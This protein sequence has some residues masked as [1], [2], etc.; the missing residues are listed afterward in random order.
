MA[1]GRIDIVP[2]L[3]PQPP[4]GNKPEMQQLFG[5]ACKHPPW[6]GSAGVQSPKHVVL[7]VPR[8]LV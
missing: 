1:F 7:S 6:T 4:Q 3:S 5:L 2:P 8:Q